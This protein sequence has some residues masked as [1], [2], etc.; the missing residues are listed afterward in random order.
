MFVVT[1][2]LNMEVA[3]FPFS[4]FCNLLREWKIVYDFQHNKCTKYM[5]IDAQIYDNYNTIY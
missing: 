3:K 1:L 2:H 4:V 5:N